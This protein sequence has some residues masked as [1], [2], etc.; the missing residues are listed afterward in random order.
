M[1][2]TIALRL[3]S[4]INLLSFLEI[5]NIVFPGVNMVNNVPLLEKKFEFSTPKVDYSKSGKTSSRYY[6]CFE[7][8]TGRK[9]AL[10]SQDETSITVSQFSSSTVRLPLLMPCWKWLLTVETLTA[11]CMVQAINSKPSAKQKYYYYSSAYSYRSDPNVYLWG[12]TD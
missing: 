2:T 12:R 10:T 11:L 9:W 4:Q 3:Y 1:F 8:R 5:Q 7:Q 6:V